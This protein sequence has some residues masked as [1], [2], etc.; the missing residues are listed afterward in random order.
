MKRLLK[1]SFDLSLLSF[2]P[3][4]S[5]FLLG[6]IVDKNLINI[7]T[8]TYPLQFIYYI[9]K[10]IFSTG[11]NINKEKDNNKNAVM[12]GMFIGTIVAII[13]F[14]IILINIDNYIIFMNMDVN[15]YK[16]FTIYSVLQLF[17]CLEFAMILNK[18]Y[19][20]EKNSLA[21]K[22]SLIFNLLNFILLIGT[23]L[24][25][26][27]QITI[28]TVTLIPL[29]LFTI[30]IYVK[31]NE[32]FKLQLDIIKCIKYDST[33]LFNNIAFFLIFLFGL[34][35]A[36]EF[37][38]QFSL[39][40]TFVALI[41]DTQWDTTDAIVTAATIDISKNNFNYKEHRNNA[42]KLLGILFLTSLFMF[43]CLY[44]FYDLDFKITMIYFGFEIINF[45]MYPI[46]RIKTCYLQL[47]WSA[48]KTTTNKIISSILRMIMSLLK[49][50]F[51]TG[52]GQ[53]C[54][55]IYQFISVSIFFKQNY[56]IDKTG[57]VTKKL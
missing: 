51:C 49:T 32:K 39:A 16:T 35:N 23:S 56:N 9:L 36:L 14:L 8:L 34:S 40:L 48:L 21:N 6:I 29:A 44:G 28:I 52:I 38:E 24:I 53:L 43:V 37:G 12:S 57:K 13:I 54:S 55:S 19:Y 1:I 2:I 17:V 41:T 27:N 11:A 3:I 25:T 46:Y 33:E 10:S 5:W 47:E 20:E 30:Y 7:F 31:N 15:I 45:I 18:L 42:Y 22:Y 4:I 26:K 50:P